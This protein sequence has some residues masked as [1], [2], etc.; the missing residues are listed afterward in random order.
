MQSSYKLGVAKHEV[1]RDTKLPWV[2]LCRLVGHE[3]VRSTRGNIEELASKFRQVGYIPCLGNFLVSE[4]LPRGEK[5]HVTQEEEKQWV[6]SFWG[7]INREFEMELSLSKNW[8]HLKGRK[9]IVLDGNHHLKAWMSQINTVCRHDLSKFVRIKCTVTYFSPDEEC[10][11]LWTLDYINSLTQTHVKR[12]LA[13][14]IF[15][16]RRLGLGNEYS[17][18]KFFDEEALK[19]IDAEIQEDKK[20]HPWIWWKIPLGLLMQVM[21]LVRYML[22]TCASIMKQLL[23]FCFTY[24]VSLKSSYLLR[25]GHA[26]T[27]RQGEKERERERQLLATE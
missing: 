10:S 11:M 17:W 12:T 14:D 1:H 3:A 16:I 23:K 9:L 2:P 22:F 18:R 27:E 25:R 7:A 6:A 15:L 20:V 5:I 21:Y 4:S 19:E 13:S 8:A 24:R 26:L